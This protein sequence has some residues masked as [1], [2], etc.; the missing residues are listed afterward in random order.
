MS[1]SIMKSRTLAMA[2]GSACLV[3]CVFNYLHIIKQKDSKQLNGLLNKTK[4]TVI[5]HSTSTMTHNQSLLIAPETILL[6]TNSTKSEPVI[7]LGFPFLHELDVLHIKLQA[8]SS[9]VDYFLISE[10]CYTQRGYKKPLWF[11]LSKDQN[12][13]RG[14]SHKIWHIIDCRIPKNTDE[15]LG[16]V[17]TDQAKI[18]I[19]LA[20]LALSTLHEDSLVVIGDADEV[21]SLA[22]LFWL[23]SQNMRKAVTYEFRTTMPHYIYGFKWRAMPYGYSTMT[24]RGIGFERDFWI[25]KITIRTLNQ[26]ILPI[27]SDVAEGSWHCSYCLSDT[28]CIEKMKAANAV[29]GPLILGNY[30]WTENTIHALKGCGISPQGGRCE[31]IPINI[32]VNSMYSHL[33]NMPECSEYHLPFQP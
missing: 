24:A 4:S 12:R 1:Y 27:P 25:S 16:W 18:N 15:A 3:L 32:S 31:N 7:I 17:Q 2:T 14:Y 22:S 11:N 30:N 33:V 8:L 10:A 13:F 20:L 21:P 28:E 26:R 19:G 6:L 29:D 5:S 23:R 9:A